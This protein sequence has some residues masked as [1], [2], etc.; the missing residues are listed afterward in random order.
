MTENFKKKRKQS[1]AEKPISLK[2]LEF[3]EAVSDLLKVK[4]IKAQENMNNDVGMPKCRMCGHRRPAGRYLVVMD[5]GGRRQEISEYVC[6][7]CWRLL[8]KGGRKGHFFRATG[9]R[10]WLYQHHEH[11]E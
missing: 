9:Q 11:L 8:N 1:N 4:P 10:W 2:P 6:N 7:P 3:D 5:V